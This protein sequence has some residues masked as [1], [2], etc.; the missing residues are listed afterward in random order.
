MSFQPKDIAYVMGGIPALQNGVGGTPSGQIQA[1]QIANISAGGGIVGGNATVSQIANNTITAAQ[2]AANAV[3]GNVIAN[4]SIQA[5]QL[6]NGSVG[7]NALAS[8]IDGGGILANSITSTQIRTDV[9]QRINGTLTAAN[10]ANLGTGITVAA[11][12]TGQAYH[13]IGFSV[14]LVKAANAIA[15]ANGA[16]VVL[17]CNGVN[18]TAGNIPAAMFTGNAS[19]DGFHVAAAGAQTLLANTPLILKTA[20]AAAFDTGTNQTAPFNLW[21]SLI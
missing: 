19:V 5:N 2:L 12:V 10:I 7:A 16:N 8:P 3:T 20:N 15:F 4:F 11:N 6:A 18:V 21:V 17:Q 14:S 9:I 13:V 1:Y